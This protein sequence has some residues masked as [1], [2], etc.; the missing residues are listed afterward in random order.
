MA[1]VQVTLK[2]GELRKL[3]KS[4]RVQAEVDR[5]GR[6][7]AGAAG[8]GFAYVR[9]PGRYTARG[10]V[11]TQNARAARRQARDAVLER[12]LDAAKQ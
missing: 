1:D 4:E 8:D 7:V 10:Y 12:S 3:M 5:V 9:R 2:M 11:Q 6:I